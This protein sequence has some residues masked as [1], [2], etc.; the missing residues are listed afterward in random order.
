MQTFQLF[1]HNC[2]FNVQPMRTLIVTAMSLQQYHS[3][4]CLRRIQ[5]FSIAI[6]VE[7]LG[8]VGMIRWVL[9]IPGYLVIE[10]SYETKS[11]EY[12]PVH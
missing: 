12:S 9:N 3:I 11:R 1:A 6:L 4:P 8:V 7:L 5:Q 10:H 2:L